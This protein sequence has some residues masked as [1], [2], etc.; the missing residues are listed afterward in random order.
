MSAQRGTVFIAE[1]TDFE[2]FEGEVYLGT[3]SAHL[4]G[5]HALLDAVDGVTLDEALAWGRER[6]DTVLLRLADSGYFWAGDEPVEGCPRWPDGHGVRRRRPSGEEWRDRAPGDEPIRWWVQVDLKPPLVRPRPDWAAA[7]RA[8]AVRADALRWGRGSAEIGAGA[9][10]SDERRGP[11]ARAGWEPVGFVIELEELAPTAGAA[12]RAAVARCAVPDGWTAF[13]VGCPLDQRPVPVSATTWTAVSEWTVPAEHAVH[14]A[15][16]VRQD[17]R[18]ASGVVACTVGWD[19]E[20]TITVRVT[21]D[22]PSA[23]DAEALAQD[24][25]DRGGLG[26]LG[27]EIGWVQTAWAVRP[28]R[29]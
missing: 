10:L 8:L 16:A 14:M 25:V 1:D 19:G 24:A 28:A 7:V 11:R 29:R 3:F 13:A 18:R 17:L 20:E 5:E 26:E 15:A 23:G 6:S 2:P 22:A 27:E 9:M 21:V 12:M 4:E